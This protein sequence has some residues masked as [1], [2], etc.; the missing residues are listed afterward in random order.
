MRPDAVEAVRAHLAA[1][2]A[3][4]QQLGGAEAA[5]TRAEGDP[6]GV[7]ARMGVEI[8]AE[9][10]AKLVELG[11]RMGLPPALV[12]KMALRALEVEL[13]TPERRRVTRLVGKERGL[14]EGRKA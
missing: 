9:T 8:D 2:A 3:L 10:F 7:D 1:G 12:L 6:I 5:A 4:L 11:A 13:A 14:L